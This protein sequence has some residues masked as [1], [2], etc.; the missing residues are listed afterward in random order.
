MVEQ[1]SC[2]AIYHTYNGTEAA[3]QHLQE[4]AF[5]TKQISVIG[6]HSQKSHAAG[7]Y[8][9]ADRTRFWGF[10]GGFWE[11]FHGMLSDA[12]LFWIPELGPVVMAGRLVA[13]LA[14]SLEGTVVVSG[15]SVLGAVLYSIGIP[16]DSIIRYETALKSDQ[17]LIIVHG[18]Q[19][20]VE[21]VHEILATTEPADVAIHLS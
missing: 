8:Q 9:T 4:A 16:K 19:H 7:F 13:V 15:L 18:N 10:H 12:A 14:G 3:L 2:V 11:R 20:E 21:Q 6:S 17:Y 5:D 1:N